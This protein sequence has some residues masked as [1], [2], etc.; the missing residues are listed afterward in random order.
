MTS[1][2]SKAIASEK[3]LD[4]VSKRL[5]LDG[6]MPLRGPANGM[7]QAETTTKKGDSMG[8]GIAGIEKS[9]LP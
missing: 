6:N 8:W 7:L 1:R 9:A 2:V 5:L 3:T 4:G